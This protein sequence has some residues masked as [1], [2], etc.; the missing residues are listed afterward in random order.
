MSD[1]TW[2]LYSIAV[3]EQRILNFA[4][5]LCMSR[6]FAQRVSKIADR[7]VPIIRIAAKKVPNWSATVR[8]GLRIFNAGINIFK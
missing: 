5:S 7:V 4:S 3:Y 6:W 1:N 2:Y 8:V